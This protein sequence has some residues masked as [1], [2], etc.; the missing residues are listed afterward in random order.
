MNKIKSALVSLQIFVNLAIF[1]IATLEL[2][3]K[4]PLLWIGISLTV[5]PLLAFGLWR[6]FYGLHTADERESTIT[7]FALIGFAMVL[8]GD[9]DRGFPLLVAFIGLVGVLVYVYWTT[10]LMPVSRSA[11]KKIKKWPDFSFLDTN[12]QPQK[13]QS[14]QKYLVIWLHGLW[15]PASAIQLRQLLPLLSAFEQA[16]IQT[17]CISLHSAN[18]AK[19]L[20]PDF[21]VLLWQDENAGCAEQLGLLL[22][23]RVP[24]GLSLLGYGDDALIPALQL[25][26]VDNDGNAVVKYSECSDNYRLPPSL[27]DLLSRLP[28]LLR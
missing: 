18:L 6:K 20:L 12:Q 2:G 26:A 14:G 5:L 9:S 15:S 4:R 16:G 22:R 24:L 3:L 23:G 1:L 11:A 13:L 21:P 25:I 10:S 28:A 19:K 8:V 27:Q 17:V 7:L